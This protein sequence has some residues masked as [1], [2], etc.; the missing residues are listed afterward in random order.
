MRNRLLLVM[1]GVVA[2]VLAVHD[3]PLA[4][5]LERVE[6]DRLTTGLERDAFILAGRSEEALEAGTVDGD[7]GIRAIVARY[8]AEEDVRVAIV[9]AGGIGVLGSDAGVV[10]QDF[11]NRPEIVQALQ[12]IPTTGGRY[13]Q[14]LGDS[15]FFVAV[16]VLSG[17]KISGAIRLSAPE[18]VVADRVSEKVRGLFVVAGISLMMAL[19]VAWLFA[20]SVT[21]P[22]EQLEVATE[23]LAAGDLGARADA[24]SG[25]HEVTS[26]AGSFNQMADRLEQ[27]V[28]RQ[29][30]F[31]GDASHQLRTPLTALRLRLEQ[32]A[33]QLN[34]GDAI[35]VHVAEAIAET[36]RLRR[37]IEGL[38]ALTH[39]DDDAATPIVVDVSLVANDRLDYWSALADEVGVTL[40][41]TIPAGVQAYAVPGALEQIIDNLVDNALEVSPVG[42]SLQVLVEPGDLVRLH[43][44]DEG[45]GMTVDERQAAFRRFWRADGAP[46]G[47]SG[48][49]LAIVEQLASAGGA[50]VELAEAPSGGVDAVVTL[51]SPSSPPSRA[52]TAPDRSRTA[53]RTRADR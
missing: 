37:M 24:V 21:R 4:R 17:A 43:V 16:P 40:A 39:A 50:S 5:H 52:S 1:V 32:L 41:G 25:P 9:D 8:N 47:G 14:T 51:R 12:G 44:I 36:D 46:A 7:P 26:L 23:R 20:R 10:G 15:L 11:T 13:S 31:A 19:A 6:R 48:L 29:R 2:V 30:S 18:R 35:G 28:D 38:L 33:D 27:L 34:D 49:G 42:S 3:I 53:H 22:L 45:P